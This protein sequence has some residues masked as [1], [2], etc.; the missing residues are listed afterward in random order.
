MPY[1]EVERGVRLFYTDDGVAG[2]PPL[3]LVHGWGTD[4]HQ[5]SWH[6]DA[7]SSAHRVLAVDLRGHGYSSVPETGNTPRAMAGDLDVLLDRLAIPQVVAVGH[8]M[9]GQVVS[10]LA[11]EH[12]E[13]VRALV[14]LDPGYGMS[15]EI[16]RGFPRMIAGLKGERPHEAA[17]RIDEWCTNAATPAVI[18]RWHKRRLYGM[19]P[20]VLV[21]AFE[22]MFTGPGAIG[23]RPA[24]DEYL[25]RRRCPVLSI[26]ADAGRASWEAGLLKDPASV[27]LSWEGASHRLHE[28]RPDD[29]VNAVDGWLSRL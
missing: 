9:G 6:I 3:L 2:S 12:P 29:F 26:W 21:Q 11:V 17:E 19:P 24:S 5:W 4:S 23:V 22:A 7:L 25:A 10:I 27:V 15:A 13:R 20:H 1:A 18:R 16:A 8:S 14:T 28:E